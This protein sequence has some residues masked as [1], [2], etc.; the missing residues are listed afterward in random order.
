MMIKNTIIE[1]GFAIIFF[2]MLIQIN[3]QV[4]ELNRKQ[5]IYDYHVQRANYFGRETEAEIIQYMDNLGI[6]KPRDVLLWNI[7]RFVCLGGIIIPPI[8]GFVYDMK[9]QNEK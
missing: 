3:P 7:I 1:I 4:D 6:E 8:D 9:I 2:I 5:E